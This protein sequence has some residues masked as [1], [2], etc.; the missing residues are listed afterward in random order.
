VS[1]HRFSRDGRQVTYTA[2]R[3]DKSFVVRVGAPYWVKRGDRMIAVAAQEVE[4][5]EYDWVAFPSFSSDDR[6]M[7]YSA[8]TGDRWLAVVDQAEGV[9]YDLISVPVFSPDGSRVAYW[10]KSGERWF[11]V[12][13]GSELKEYEGIS[14]P[15]GSVLTFDSPTTFHSIV[16]RGE[17]YIRLDMEIVED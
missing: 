4:E 15:P 5:K 7:A 1:Y 16:S 11:V 17:E 9:E 14:I 3:G 13:D 8:R 10:A 6:R 12:V 2:T